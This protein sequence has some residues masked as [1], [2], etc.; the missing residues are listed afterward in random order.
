M[1]YS[2]KTMR[3]ISA[4]LLAFTILVGC[5]NKNSENWDVQ[6]TRMLVVSEQPYIEAIN[7]A[8]KDFPI[9]LNHLKNRNQN[10][11]DFY[12]KSKYSEGDIVENIWF[13]VDTLKAETFISR[14]ANVPLKLKNIKLDDTLEIRKNE[15][16]DWVIYKGDSLVIGNYIATDI[17]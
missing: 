13:V 17:K 10:H 1:G 15:V 14:L 2:E 7:K 16:I 12:I 5:K 9:F 8:R 4:L 3:T 6:N 11:F